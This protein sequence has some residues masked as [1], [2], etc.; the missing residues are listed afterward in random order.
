[1]IKIQP[2]ND[3]MGF[4]D[5]NSQGSYFWGQNLIKTQNGLS[6]GLSSV[7]GVA[8]PL[9]GYYPSYS[10]MNYFPI[11][12]YAEYYDNIIFVTAF[13]EAY[14]VNSNGTIAPIHA[15]REAIYDYPQG[16]GIIVDQKSRILIAGKRYLAMFDPSDFGGGIKGGM[17]TSAGTLSCTLGSANVVC[18][19]GTLFNAGMVGKTILIASAA[20]D[21]DFVGVIQVYVNPTTV[22]MDRQWS[23]ATGTANKFA[24]QTTINDQWKDFGSQVYNSPYD[25]PENSQTPMELY[26]SDV[27]IGRNNNVCVLH[28]NDDSI[29]TDAV[30]G[31]TMPRDFRIKFIKAGNGG[32]LIGAVLQG[33]SAM[34]LWDGLA[35]RS[36][37]PW[38]WIDEKVQSA[39]YVDGTWIVVTSRSVISTNGYSFQRLYTME[40]PSTQVFKTYPQGNIVYNNKLIIANRAQNSS[41]TKI[42]TGFNIL[43]LVTKKWSFLPV[44]KKYLSSGKLTYRDLTAEG[45]GNIYL[46]VVEPGAIFL[47][48]DASISASMFIKDNVYTGKIRTESGGKSILIANSL[49]QGSSKKVAQALR[50]VVSPIKEYLGLDSALTY[51]NVTVTAKIASVNSKIWQKVTITSTSGDN[52]HI[53]IGTVPAGYVSPSVG[54]EVICLM[55]GDM[56]SADMS[57]AGEIRHITAVANPGAANETWTLDSNL[58]YAPQTGDSFEI[59]PFKKIGA[60][61]IDS[62]KI[63]EDVFFDI[64]DNIKARKFHVKFLIENAGTM[65]IEIVDAQFIYDDLGYF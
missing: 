64:K 12:S 17:G 2:F 13:G 8:L 32:V 60:V 3:F 46:P 63:K 43:D 37:A 36:I 61:T 65:P 38:L 35:D 41:M 16:N 5:D 25:S 23:K 58:P 29:N 11:M 26:E 34:V 1:M 59:T 19:V 39:S 49:G 47:K 44:G 21:Y 30:P 55:P 24:V 51:G 10:A 18:S 27:L 50:L 56:F 53:T 7:K 57:N 15:M 4:A 40:N 48:S 20:G 14:V 9:V 52:S 22:T 31:F 42:R 33:R 28:T 62:K 54:D 6:D 45:F